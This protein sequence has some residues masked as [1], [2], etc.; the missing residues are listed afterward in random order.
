MSAAVIDAFFST[1]TSNPATAGISEVSEDSLLESAKMGDPAPFAELCDRYVPRLFRIANRITRNREDAEDAV[2][3]SLLRAFVHIRDFDARSAFGTWLTRI[4]INSAL[5]ILRK[6]RPSLE[7][8][9]DDDS[10]LDVLSCRIADSAPNPEKRYLQN[11]QKQILTT[12]IQGLRPNLRRILEIQQTQECSMNE[13]ARMMGI[14]V[15]AAKGR[16]FHAKSALRRSSLLRAARSGRSPR[17]L[18]VM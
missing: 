13:T 11:E 5:M 10:C 9:M 15:A 3:D 4:V 18:P 7:L 6:K 12:A 16:L 1:L 14:S 17:R 8:A 2:Q